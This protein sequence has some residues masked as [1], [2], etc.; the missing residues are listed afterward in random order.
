MR[1]IPGAPQTVAQESITGRMLMDFGVNN[2]DFF[3]TIMRLFADEATLVS[4]LDV[5]GLKTNGLNFNTNDGSY[6]TVGSNHI[7]Y[8]IAASDERKIHLRA[9]ASGVTYIDDANITNIGQN[10]TPFYIFVD[11]NWAGYK[12]VIEL[13]DNR[14]LLYIL[15]DPEE[16]TNSTWK[17]KVR[18][19]TNDKT[20]FVDPM[21]LADDAEAAAVMTAHEH[22]FSERGVEKYTFDGWGDAYLTLQRFKYSWSGTAKAMGKSVSG[23]WAIHNGQKTFL[24]H[25]EEEMMRRAAQYLEYQILFGKTTVTADTRKVILH[26]DNGREVMAGSGVMYSGDGPI[27]IP[28]NGYTKK[29]LESFLMNIDSYIT[30]GNDGVREVALLQAPRASLAFHACMRD[31]GVTQNNNV[32]GDGAAKGINDTYAYYE[33][34]GIRIVPRRTAWFS[35]QRR[36][37]MK[38]ADGTYSNEWDALALPLG[39]TQD[40]KRN[41][42]ELV[43]LRPAAKGT[44]AGIDEGGNIASSVDGSSSHILF[45]NG[46]ISVVQPIRMY[47]PYWM[48]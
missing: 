40:G 31:M 43:Q 19:F 3:P 24:T 36:P 2:P 22:D 46:V 39:L 42:I 26:D 33:L 25:A 5:K 45:Q 30:R 34:D 27:D 1:L 6:R 17:L 28:Y 44:V 13:G 14:T 8:A 18:V 7:Q 38:L 29:F 12:E 10:Q 32:V 16:D 37:G 9:N 21:L 41:G 20:D 48:N 35:A 4:L 11:S 23:K 15:K 47:R